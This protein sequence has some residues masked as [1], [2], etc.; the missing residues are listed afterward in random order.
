[1]G[2]A[3]PY[4]A[5]EALFDECKSSLNFVRKM[6][7]GGDIYNDKQGPSPDVVKRGA[8]V[9]ESIKNASVAS[10]D[11]NIV[12][13]V[14]DEALSRLARYTDALPLQD[15]S[16]MLDAVPEIVNVVTVCFFDDCIE[17]IS[18]PSI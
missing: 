4:I 7:R 5:M 13:D 10:D 11:D 8:L 15:Y 12:V 14:S 6:H 9:A 17:P 18:A 16:D 3:A 1:V 2:N